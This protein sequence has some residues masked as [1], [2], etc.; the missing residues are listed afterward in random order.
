MPNGRNSKINQDV[1]ALARLENLG[2][3]FPALVVT[4]EE[5]AQGRNLLLCTQKNNF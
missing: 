3:I 5:M 2:Y 1:F 4:W